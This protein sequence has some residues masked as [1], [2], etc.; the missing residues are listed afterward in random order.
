MTDAA[1]GA[2]A[3]R[4]LTRQMVVGDAGRAALL[5]KSDHHKLLTLGAAA[6]ATRVFIKASPRLTRANVNSD[7][8]LSS[9]LKT[10][11]GEQLKA[12]DDQVSV[13]RARARPSL[14]SLQQQDENKRMD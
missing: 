5:L 3:L 10:Q 12:R 14:N 7:N 6:A 4:T 11:S 8:I 13:D 9:A 1:Y 2:L